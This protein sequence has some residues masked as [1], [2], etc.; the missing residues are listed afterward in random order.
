MG[1]DIVS[2]VESYTLDIKTREMTS[3]KTVYTFK[4]GT[5]EEG[6]VTITRDVE[7]PEKMKP[8][9]AYEETTDTR[10]ITIVSNPGTENEKTD[11]IQ[12]AKGLQVSFTPDLFI[13]TNFTMYSDE[14]CTQPVE[15]LDV[16]SDLTVYIKWD[17]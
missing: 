9:L 17:E 10:T 3:I 8:F 7:I 13:E 4:D 6:I 11:T 12:V 5:V 16:Y 2:S 14:A 15:E 1:D